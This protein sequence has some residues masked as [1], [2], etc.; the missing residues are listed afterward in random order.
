M[1]EGDYQVMITVYEAQELEC[2]GTNFW[3]LETHK[4]TCDAFV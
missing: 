3:I 2:R 4:T 1:R